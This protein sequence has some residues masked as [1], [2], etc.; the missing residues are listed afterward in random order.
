M[1][2]YQK[3]EQI[4]FMHLFK[5]YYNLDFKILLKNLFIQVKR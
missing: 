5:T 3:Q 2:K 1:N 4:Y